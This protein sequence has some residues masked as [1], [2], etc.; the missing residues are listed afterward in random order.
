MT[1]TDSP[2]APLAIITGASSGIGREL[3]REFAEHGFELVVA[4]EDTELAPAAGALRASTKARVLEVQADLADY[5][6]VEQV[7]KVNGR[8]EAGLALN[9]GVGLGGV[10]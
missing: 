2:P 8:P 4:A 9:A 7:W 1:T 10:A 5:Q 6:G 3:A